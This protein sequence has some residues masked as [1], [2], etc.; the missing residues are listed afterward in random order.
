MPK[1]PPSTEPQSPETD[2]L[3][4]TTSQRT[5]VSDDGYGPLP[6]N[7]AQMAGPVT[8]LADHVPDDATPLLST[9]VVG[10][11]AAKRAAVAAAQPETA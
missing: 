10:A 4:S 9:K 6:E 8:T 5:Y 2:V 1:K 3:P 11:P 7:P